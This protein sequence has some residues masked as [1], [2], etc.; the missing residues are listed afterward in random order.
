MKSMERR[1]FLKTTAGAGIVMSGTNMFASG[2]ANGTTTNNSLSDNIKK[3]ICTLIDKQAASIVDIVKD[4]GAH[5]ELGFKEFRTSDVVNDYLRAAGYDT[6]RGLAITGLKATW[7][8]NSTGPNIAILAEL[9]GIICS[10][11]SW[12]D[13]TTGATHNCGHNLQLGMMMAVAKAFQQSGASSLL[14]GNISFIATPAEEYIELGYRTELR[15][16]GK[17]RY[18]GGKQEL[19]WQGVF[20]DV[21]AAMMVHSQGN[22]PQPFTT[23]F[24][25]SIGLIAKMI[26]YTGKTAH[27]GIAAEDGINALYAAVAGINAVNALRETFRD[28][29]RNRI[30]FIITKG[31]EVVNSVPADARLE[32]VVRANNIPSMRQ[33]LE[34]SERAWRAGGDA[35]GAS[36]KIN[37]LSGYLPLACDDNLN[38]L[39][40]ENALQY[41]P[42][43][44]VSSVDFFKVSTDMGD[45]TNLMPG[46]QPMVG[47][48]NGALHAANFQAADYKTAVH[49]PAKIVASTLVDLLIDDAARMR[50]IIEHHKP[51]LSRQAYFELMDSFFTM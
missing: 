46:I 40:A 7:K 51:L 22:T 41:I 15:N 27:A 33:L 18:F 37:R 11:S 24:R 17:L 48:V 35:L 43:N 8:K 28:E 6:K 14:G 13:K 47:G 4:I 30:H 29:D 31:G 1:D 21:D 5:P 32:C 38:R 36:T 2:G 42:E 44:Q 19:V 34:K 16:S 9:D 20:D 10:E 25:N 49:I 12:A 50:S 39:F 45:I 3:E 26:Q 23:V